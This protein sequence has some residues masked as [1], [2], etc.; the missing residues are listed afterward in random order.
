[1]TQQQTRTMTA[2]HASPRCQHINLQELPCGAPALRGRRFC[3][4]HQ[5][6]DAPRGYTVPPIEDAAGIQLALMQVVRALHDK[7]I[8]T[9]TASLTLYALQV[10]SMNLKRFQAER[11]AAFP[12]DQP[13]PG[14]QL[15]EELKRVLEEE[16]EHPGSI[17]E[18]KA[19]AD[20]TLGHQVTTSP[21][22]QVRVPRH[23]VTKF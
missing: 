17:P 1:M 10:A 9:K 2:P 15:I 11:D 5:H 3:R 12:V 7:A 20:S 22:H 23:Q 4:F 16:R 6:I 8:D 13:H 18:I 19:A 21:R 14:E